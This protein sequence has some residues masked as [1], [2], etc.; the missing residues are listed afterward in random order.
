MTENELKVV[1]HY[2][3]KEDGS[4]VSNINPPFDPDGSWLVENAGELV[5][6]RPANVIDAAGITYN[7]WRPIVGFPDYEITRDGRVRARWNDFIPRIVGSDVILV[8]DDY[9]VSKEVKALVEKTFPR[10]TLEEGY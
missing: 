4:I 5:Y 1:A 7:E 10:T 6:E 2:T 9:N 3:I 8:L